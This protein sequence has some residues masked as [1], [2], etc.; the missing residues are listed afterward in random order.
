LKILN[1]GSLNIDH[2]YK[3]PHMVRPG[4]TLSSEALDHFAGGKGANQSVAMAK[5]GLDV[6]HAGKIGEDG[7]WLADLLAKYG[8]HTE[9][10]RR[11]DGPTGHTI[12]Q[13]TPEGENSIIL[14]GGGNRNITIEEIKDTFSRFDAGDYVVLQNEINFMPEIIREA[15]RTGLKICLNPAPIHEDVKSW[16]LD[17]VDTLVVNEIEGQELAGQDGDFKTVLDALVSCYPDTDIL[18]TVGKEGAFF[19]GGEQREYVPIV[20][21]PVV[22]TTAA[23]DTFF[24]YFLAS[25]IAGLSVKSAMERAT[26]ASAIT[27]SRPG[28][29]DAIPMA[30]ELD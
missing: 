5:A 17:L 18:M 6:W 12:I 8:V 25:R 22:D 14:Y 11:Y 24:G 15:H 21:S 23:G 26:R 2:V 28:A 3:V 7:R 29:M 27:V 13:V 10:I 1:F 16:P 9:L 30:F 4:E 20:D 19:G